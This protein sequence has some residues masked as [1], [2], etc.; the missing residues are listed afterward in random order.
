MYLR[1]DI[2]Q[3]SEILTPL[4]SSKMEKTFQPSDEQLQ[5]FDQLKKALAKGPIFSKLVNLTAPKVILTDSAGTDRGSF[6]AVL[7]QIVKPEHQ[8]KT[9][10]PGY[11]FEDPLHSLLYDKRLPIRPLP[12][13]MD[14]EDIKEYSKRIQDDQPPE[15]AYLRD[16]NLGYPEEHVQNSLG[17]TLQLLLELNKVQTPIGDILKRT[18]Q[19]IRTSMLRH[20]FT[21]F[22]FGQDKQKF[23]SYIQNLESGILKADKY[24]LIFEGLAKAMYRPIIV[25]TNTDEATPVTEHN[26]DKTKPPFVFLMYQHHGELIVRPATLNNKNSFNLENLT[27]MFEIVSYVSKRI[28]PTLSSLHIIELE[29][30]GIL[31]AL[32]SFAKLVGKHAECVLLT[33]AK[34]VYYLFNSNALAASSKLQRWNY[35]L[36]QTMPQLKISYLK[37]Q[38]NLADWLSRAYSANLPDVKRLALP[39]YIKPELDAIL[40]SYKIWTTDEWRTFV[41]QHPNYLGY[42]D[43][44]EP[45]KLTINTLKAEKKAIGKVLEPLKVLKQRINMK[46]VIDGQKQEYKEIYENCLKSQKQSYEDKKVSYTLQDSILFTIIDDESR[47]LL[48]TKLLPTFIAYTHLLLT[49]SGEDKMLLNLQNFYHPNLKKLVR[50]YCRACFGCQLQNSPT[51]LEKYG[52]YPTISRPFETVAVDYIQSLPP[53]HGYHHIL[54]VVCQLTGA[55][56]VFP[57]KSLT[58]REFLNNYMFNIHTLY[59]PTRILCDNATAFLEKQNLI[60]LASINVRV[61][62]ASAY[63]SQSKGLVEASNKLIKWALIKTLANYPTAHWVQILP[64]IARLYNTMKSSKTGYSPLELLFGSRSSL[65]KDHF[66]ILPTEHYHPLIKGEDEQVANLNK[67]LED[68]L[69]KAKKHIETEREKRL[70]KLNKSRIHKNLQPGDLILVRNFQITVGVNTSLRP[71]FH[72]SPYRVLNIGPHTCVCQR[73]S[74]QVIQKLNL[75]HVKKF[76]AMDPEFDNLPNQIKP[77]ITKPFNTLTNEEIQVLITADTLPLPTTVNETDPQPQVKPNSPT[78]EDKASTLPTVPSDE[79]E[80]EEHNTQN[81][82]DEDDDDDFDPTTSVRAHGR[83]FRNIGER[84]VR[85]QS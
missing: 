73:L 47:I 64:L 70:K 82:D 25:I 71:I 44:P 35:K 20:K 39:R 26:A 53:S 36:L 30:S 67:E 6:S 37:G 78:K 48:P 65:A 23:Q 4:T 38:D 74:D 63:Y 8:V 57:M 79:P 85:F 56:L 33:D 81:D 83:V 18:S 11:N 28:T 9:L 45:P 34:C 84:A 59:Q 68:N 22:I 50:A 42:D 12:L 72:I 19:H 51:R 80:P 29:L 1:F 61:L 5:A 17:I 32:S 66:G 24:Q 76:N 10:P 55:I 3:P 31:Y 54:T 27:S 69:A 62:Y 14:T 60:Y 21:E 75:N 77:I 46:N 52:A 2:L 58:S 16:K 49:H 15:H 13:K 40:P 41:D 7:A 43:I